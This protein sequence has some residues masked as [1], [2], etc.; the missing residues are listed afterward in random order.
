MMPAAGCAVVQRRVRGS[1]GV[2]VPRNVNVDAYLERM[3]W[4]GDRAPT[5]ATLCA[6]HRAHMR[7]VPFE[8][9]D[10]H[11][12]REIVLADELLFAKIV[13]RRRGGFCYEL[14]GLVGGLLR[15]LGFEVAY[16]SA[17]VAS[18][19][20]FTPEFDHL[21][22]LVGNEPTWLA[23]VGFDDSFSEPL[24]ISTDAPQLRDG[25]PYRVLRRGATYTVERGGEGLWSGVYRFTAVARRLEDFAPRCHY[26]Q[27]SPESHFT[28]GRVCSIAT[29][30]GRATLRERRLIETSD[31]V[32]TERELAAGEVDGV[33]RERFGV[34]L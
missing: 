29:P 25:E 10:I 12:G 19:D 28:T 20:D 14:N 32:R 30:T 21:A 15:A 1:R 3:Q 2:E 9:L 26:H 22:L 31:G 34:V 27:T 7:A 23:D 16:V 8:N 33:L 4:A 13:E 24:E 6:L 18:G 5:Q 11:R 17:R